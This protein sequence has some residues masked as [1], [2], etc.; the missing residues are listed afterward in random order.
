M[1]TPTQTPARILAPEEQEITEQWGKSLMNTPKQTPDLK[2]RKTTEAMSFPVTPHVLQFI[3]KNGV[4]LYIKGNI[5]ICEP[6]GVTGMC[7]LS[8]LMAG[9]FCQQTYYPAVIAE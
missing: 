1:D 2:Y 3:R 7:F 6:L 9:K 5:L 4:N 8:R